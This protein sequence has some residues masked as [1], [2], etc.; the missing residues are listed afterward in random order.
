MTKQALR[1]G[2]V[3]CGSTGLAAAAFLHD[4]GH[5]VTL[6]EQFE[7]PK[8][9]GAGLLL[10]P[11]GLAALARLNLDRQAIERGAVV[12]RLYGR[13]TSGRV[14]FDLAYRDLAEQCFG[15]GIHRGTLFTLLY[16]AVRTR[17]IPIETMR[18]INK[19]EADAAGRWIEDAQGARI[20]P[21]DLVIDASGSRS[22]L[23]DQYARIRLNKRYPYGAVWAVCEDAGQQFGG[24]SL[25]QRYIGA[26]TMAGVMALGRTAA[27]N[28]ECYVTFFWSMPT[29]SFTQWREEGME[30]WKKKVHACWPETDGLLAQLQKPEDLTIA[31]Y[32]DVVLKHWHADRMAF[33]GD[34]GHCM[35][36]QLGQ[37]ANLGLIDAML[38]AD[39]LGNESNINQALANFS[40]ARRAHLRFYQRASRWLT[41]FFQS[42]L[43]SAAMLR[44]FAFGPMA[45]IPYIRREMLRTLAG[46]KTGPFSQLNPGDWHPAYDLRKRASNAAMA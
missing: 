5:N 32:G 27:A 14:I 22:A 31:A 13:T 15:L 25:Q 44:D 11:T 12:H 20:G 35:S 42:D 16:E 6:F 24:H 3:G 46:I 37:G 10:Q 2:I 21:F 45:K 7:A 18:S 28:S 23:R 33:I 9:L 17:H 38:L 8:P 40:R 34:A 26:H 4:A 30:A 39:H 19:S 29:A 43:K 36:P 1:I 41:P